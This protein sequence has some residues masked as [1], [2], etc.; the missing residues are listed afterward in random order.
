[1]RR[2][3][4]SADPLHEGADSSALQDMCPHMR[5]LWPQ[6]L[7]NRRH[8]QSAGDARWALLEPA[9]SLQHEQQQLELKQPATGGGRPMSAGQAASWALQ[10]ELREQEEAWR[11]LDS[12]LEHTLNM[13]EM[14][15][16]TQDG[17]MQRMQDLADGLGGRAEAQAALQSSRSSGAVDGVAVAVPR[18]RRDSRTLGVAVA[19]STQ[20]DLVDGVLIRHDEQIVS[21]KTASADE[22]V[23]MMEDVERERL[24]HNAMLRQADERHKAAEALATQADEM[25]RS[26]QARL[27]SVSVDAAAQGLL[28]RNLSKQK[29]ALQAQLDAAA[30]KLA[31]SETLEV[32]RAEAMM[33]LSERLHA[34]EQAVEEALEQSRRAQEEGAMNAL[35]LAAEEAAADEAPSP[36]LPPPPQSQP[37]VAKPA[38]KKPQPGSAA[39]EEEEEEEEQQQLDAVLAAPFVRKKLG[40]VEMV[41]TK[42]PPPQ[43]KPPP[44]RQ[45]TVKCL[46]CSDMGTQTEAA[47]GPNGPGAGKLGKEA[48]GKKGV[49]ALSAAASSG[50]LPSD[51]HQLVK[52]IPGGLLEQLRHVPKH[53]EGRVMVRG[54]AAPLL[55]QLLDSWSERHLL[56]LQQKLQPPTFAKHVYDSFLMKYG[57]HS[58]ADERVVELVST[59]RAHRNGLVRADL[60]GRLLGMWDAIPVHGTDF[61]LAAFSAILSGSKEKGILP[62]PPSKDATGA[63]KSSKGGKGAPPQPAEDGKEAKE[64]SAAYCSQEVARQVLPK[65]L[66]VSLEKDAQALLAKLDGTALP[67][68]IRQANLETV[69]IERVD[70]DMLL[71]GMMLL[72]SRHDQAQHEEQSNKLRM[73][74][75][76]RFKPDQA[77]AFADFEQMVKEVGGGAVDPNRALILYHR[78][79]DTSRERG[80]ADDSISAA[81]FADVLAPVA[82]MK[83]RRRIAD[84]IRMTRLSRA[85][86]RTADPEAQPPEEDA[87]EVVRLGTGAES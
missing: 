47:D 7:A 22:L 17:V 1:M 78:A 85:L 51:A 65:L 68:A 27:N 10:R 84:A 13:A 33:A 30:A 15:Q 60:V 37:A 2:W 52:L 54:L 57:M 49:A 82:R 41:E 53:L 43:P 11:H 36:A 63:A 35:S 9:G 87:E 73:I 19:A 3:H 31:D 81:V 74:F 70:F 71:S 75:Q 45:A 28:K 38:D 50:P 20:I 12:E 14:E 56:S 69:N 59:L 48:K 26:M 79:V 66:H 40:L 6:H 46:V 21:I 23:K 16:D 34:A 24:R 44:P 25:F 62:T 18:S 67:V 80:G 83:L 76:E 77:V 61:F 72:W 29:H 5:R 58:L 32:A 39:R 86:G 64:R 8:M 42:A 4:E 55:W